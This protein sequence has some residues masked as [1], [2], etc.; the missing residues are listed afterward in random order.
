MTTNLAAPIII[1]A[2]K[3]CQQ[4]ILAERIEQMR[5]SAPFLDFFTCNI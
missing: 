3:S 4:I 2:K 5:T 1:N